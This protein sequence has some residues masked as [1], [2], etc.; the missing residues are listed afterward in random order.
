MCS[1][2]DRGEYNR[3]ERTIW[4]SNR[5]LAKFYCRRA[6]CILTY[7]CIKFVRR[8]VNRDD[9]VRVCLRKTIYRCA[10]E[11]SE[12]IK[13]FAAREFDMRFIY[14]AT[15][16]YRGVC[17]KKRNIPTLISVCF[18]HVLAFTRREIYDYS[19]IW[20]FSKITIALLRRRY[21]GINDGKYTTIKFWCQVD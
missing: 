3:F 14:L 8:V 18:R 10:S 20:D 12:R 6:K 16:Q 1:R 9:S 19:N 2:R 7:N 15:R 5:L 21:C 4:S 17:F 13:L 11:L